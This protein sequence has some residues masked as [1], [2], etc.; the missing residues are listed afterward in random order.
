MASHPYSFPSPAPLEKPY[1]ESIRG[2]GGE[3]RIFNSLRLN[4][5]LTL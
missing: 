4:E 3:I 5:G 2:E 1:L